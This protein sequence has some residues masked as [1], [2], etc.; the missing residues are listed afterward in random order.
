M[1]GFDPK[2]SFG[3]ETSRRYD[4]LE[5]RGDEPETV[6]FLA[7][8]AGGRDALEF[9]IGTG[10]IVLPLARA[11]VPVEGIELVRSL[12]RGGR[13]WPVPGAHRVPQARQTRWVVETARWCRRFRAKPRARHG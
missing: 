1:E 3:D 11:G 13:G 10:R 5:T 7:R 12:M 8:L 6:A 9:A 2:M 4:A